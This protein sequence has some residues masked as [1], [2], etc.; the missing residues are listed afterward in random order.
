MKLLETPISGAHLIEVEPARDERGFFARSFCADTFRAHGLE[1]AFAQAGISYNI[2]CGT[3]RG[4][5]YQLPPHSEVKTVRC[6][7]GRVFDVIADLRPT[8]ATFGETFQVE[9]SAENRRTLY[10]PRGCAHGFQTL[11][12]DVELVYHMTAAYAP[13]AARGVRWDDPQL[14]IAWPLAPR[15]L[16]DAD[17]TWPFLSEHEKLPE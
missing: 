6:T 11:Q 5:H 3:L 17:R 4:L 9:L 2:L 14:G 16:S 10:I 8:S 7:R 13:E 15:V 12:D 1:G